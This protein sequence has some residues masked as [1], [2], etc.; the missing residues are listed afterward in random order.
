M[1]IVFKDRIRRFLRKHPQ[2]LYIQKC[3][4]GMKN[5]DFVNI[6]TEEEGTVLRIRNATNH[7]YGI[8][9]NHSKTQYNININTAGDGFFALY[10]ATLNYL[11][12]ADMLSMEPLVIWGREIAYTEIDDSE[13][14][15]NAFAYYFDIIND[16]HEAIG[17]YKVDSI[18]AHQSFAESFK[19]YDE[20]GYGY[21]DSYIRLLG[22]VA[23]K[24]ISIN[25]ITQ[26][27]LD[28]DVSK[29]CN[30]DKALGVHIR[31]TDYK[32]QCKNHPTMVGIDDYF[33]AV[34]KAI[35]KDGYEFIFLATDDKELL[36]QFINKYGTMV[37]VYDDVIRLSGK[38]SVAFS[39]NDRKRHNYLLGYEVLRD[40]YTLSLCNGF[41]GS[42]S[43]VGIGVRILKAS[44][45]QEFSYLEILDKGINKKGKDFE[46]P[47]K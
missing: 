2:L 31:G 43:Q 16:G 22:R 46:R 20:S 1:R 28:L 13:L 41:I 19:G 32:Q 7:I 24:Y 23:R 40:A 36:E 26:E 47:D 33:I 14:G 44:K 39:K 45:E 11:Y 37:F 38:E 10:R 5:P 34:D 27:K 21:N 15:D 6:M 18:W 12:F 35:K 17:T 25:E 42:M 4:S 30:M 8:D 3:V 29:L 9:D